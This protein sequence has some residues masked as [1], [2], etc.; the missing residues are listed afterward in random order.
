MVSCSRKEILSAIYQNCIDCN[1]GDITKVKECDSKDNCA[2][3]KYRLM[4][5]NKEFSD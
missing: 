2:L 1:S 5:F 4:I 3:W